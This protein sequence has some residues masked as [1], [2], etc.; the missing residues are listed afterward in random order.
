MDDSIVG[1]LYENASADGTR[2]CIVDQDGAHTYGQIWI[3]VV[4]TVLNLKDLGIKPKD[5][6]LVECT[7]D[8][9]F[10]ICCFACNLLGAYFVPIEYQASLERVS[11]IEKETEAKIFIYSTEYTLDCQCV[12]FGH[13]IKDNPG[14]GEF[15]PQFPKGED[16]AEILYTTGT[17]GKSKGIEVTHTNNIALAQNIS[18]GTQMRQ[19]NVELIPLPIS[20]SHGLRCCYANFYKGG[21]VVLVYGVSK[22]KY[23]FDLIETYQI[24]AMDLSPS[25]V[26]VLLKLSRGKLAKF[27][28]QLDYIQ[29]GTEAMPEELKSELCRLFPNVRLYNFY[30]STESGRSCVFDFNTQ[31]AKKHCIGLPTKNAC[32][33]VTD[34]NR[35]EIVSSPDNTGLLASAG[36]MN[37]KG[38]WKQ[39][40]LTAKT[41]E[42]GYIYTND[43]GYIDADGYVY[44][45]GRRDDIINYKGIKIAPD[46]IED[47]AK[48]YSGV[49]DCACVPIAD[50]LVGQLPKLFLVVDDIDGFDKKQFM[51]FLENNIDGNKMPKQLE[52]VEQIPRTSN[53]KIVRK[54]LLEG[55]K[56]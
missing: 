5:C 12:E 51:A 31:S 41:M 27:D 34:E 20:H 18:F 54:K 49:Q 32:F 4:N 24:T 6:V 47:K 1:I 52:F 40:E 29:I 22:V 7:Q 19:G 53:G 37:M 3:D 39:P 17:T 55:E 38:Y 21:T 25:A 2:L 35:R 45:L 48:L 23:I 16:T 50:K 43:E 36:A 15:T 30:G 10:L 46:E 11:D 26:S 14:R 33:I 28:S 56:L 13:V 8:A 44:V 42:N 9:R